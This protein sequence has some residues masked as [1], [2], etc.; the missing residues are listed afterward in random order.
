MNKNLGNILELVYKEDIEAVLDSWPEDQQEQT[1][2]LAMMIAQNSRE[3]KRLPRMW[4]L[5]IM[6][7]AVGTAALTY[8]LGL[9]LVISSLSAIIVG[10][11]TYTL[12]MI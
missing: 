2:L 8:T 1:I 11:V 10:I 3:I 4:V 7:L 12:K 9:D 6:S 5:L